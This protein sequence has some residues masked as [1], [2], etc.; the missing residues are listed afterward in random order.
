M[1][2]LKLSQK[3]FCIGF[4]GSMQCHSAPASFA[5]ARIAF[6]DADI[7]REM[8]RFAAERLMELEVGTRTSSSEPTP[9]SWSGRC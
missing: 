1:R 8:I 6:D 2:P 9:P 5:Q 3:P 4:P 7:L